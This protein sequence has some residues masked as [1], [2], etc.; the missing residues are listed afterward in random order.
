MNESG[1][2]Y[3]SKSPGVEKPSFRTALQE[4]PLCSGEGL[5]GENNPLKLKQTQLNPFFKFRF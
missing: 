2:N 3:S 4:L 5:F 1:I